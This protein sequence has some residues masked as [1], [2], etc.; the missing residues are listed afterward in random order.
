MNQDTTIINS[1]TGKAAVVLSTCGGSQERR[2]IKDRYYEARDAHAYGWKSDD[3]DFH[4]IVLLY[5]AAY[6][7]SRIFETASDAS[8]PFTQ[9]FQR[10][11]NFDAGRRDEIMRK[12]ARRAIATMPEVCKFSVDIDNDQFGIR[13]LRQAL[14][15]ALYE[16]VSMFVHRDN[17]QKVIFETAVELSDAY[18]AIGTDTGDS[19]LNTAIENMLKKL[20]ATPGQRGKYAD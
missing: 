14:K 5:D 19:S 13:L 3:D 1:E 16:A 12:A 7:A 8:F 6:E 11:M 10:G 4:E 9:M 20:G 15:T 2:E 18:E 17:S